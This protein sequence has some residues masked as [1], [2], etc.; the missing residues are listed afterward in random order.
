MK[1]NDVALVYGECLSS[2]GFDHPHPFS[3]ERLG[4]F[5]AELKKRGLDK[6]LDLL[7]PL[8]CKENDLLSFHTVSYIDRLKLKSQTGSGFID[9]GDTP[10]YKGVYDASLLVAGSALLMLKQVML[11]NYK[12]AFLPIGGLHHAVR[13]NA[14]GFCAVNDIAL[15]AESLRSQYGLS[16]IAYIDID[17]HHGD[18]LFYPYENDPFLI[19]ADIHQSPETLYPGTGFDYEDGKGNAKGLKLNLSLKPGDGDRAFENQWE[20]VE[21][22]LLD[23]RP[24]FILFQCGADSLGGDPITQLE[25][26]SKSFSLAARSL[27]DF[28]DKFCDG[29]LLA[30]G[31]G[32]Y[33]LN[34][35]AEGWN[36]VLEE[37]LR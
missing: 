16:K 10:A 15:V 21:K 18:G 33:N 24:E 23:K 37:I 28:A 13:D 7:K 5:W 25:L 11:G 2:Y 35:I 31:G 8:K 20:K 34:N 1:S 14:A 22:H 17:A 26:S 19:F 27:C 3:R 29:K 32:G 4:A 6:K 36:S 12:K 30:F 9:D